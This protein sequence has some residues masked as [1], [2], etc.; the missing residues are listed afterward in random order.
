L[1]NASFVAF[2]TVILDEIDHL[3]SRGQEVMYRLFELPMMASS[4]LVLIGV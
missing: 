3:S 4:R 1:S 2:S